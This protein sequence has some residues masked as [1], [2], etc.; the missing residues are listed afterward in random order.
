MAMA[1]KPVITVVLWTTLLVARAALADERADGECPA[2]IRLGEPE[3][4]Q[5]RIGV[6][7][8]ARGAVTGILATTPVPMDWPEQTVRTVAEEKTPNVGRISYRTLDG[9]VKQMLVTI[10]RLAAGVEARAIV[11]FEVAKRRI[12]EPAE[13]AVLLAP[14]KAG[15]E[16]NKYLLPSPY[17]ES[18]HPRIQS[19][20]AEI[21]AG[22]SAG[23]ESTAALFDWVRGNV[24]YEFSEQIKPAVQALEDGQGD[25]EELSSLV[26]ALCRAIKIPARAVW[27]PGHCYPEFYLEDAAGRGHWYPCQAAGADRQFGSMIEDR[28]ILQ[29]G[30]NFKV[31]EER[32]PQRYVKQFLTAKNAA[33][34]PAVEFVLERVGQ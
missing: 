14:T 16:L 4:S 5:W 20:A 3:T 32:G 24:K 30:D 7:V 34:D 31:P 19:L 22:K 10:P 13:T 12:L 1:G 6:V 23:W 28:P 29:K 27:I 15:R 25:C 33:A 17:I 18:K 2:A 8:K 11:T 9:G 26:I 21:T